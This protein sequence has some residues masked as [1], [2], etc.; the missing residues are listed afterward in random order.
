MKKI[1]YLTI[2]ISKNNKGVYNKIITKIEELKK[3]V[4]VVWVNISF[5]EKTITIDNS[6][7]NFKNFH[8]EFLQ[9][10]NQK[11]PIKG[12]TILFRHLY[13]NKTLS[14][15][16]SNNIVISE[17]N[18][19][20][21]EEYLTELLNLSFR[22][23]FYLIR[24]LKIFNNFHV[25]YYYKYLF[26][27]YAKNIKAFIGVTDEIM[28]Y[29]KKY[30][31][32]KKNC[33]VSNG[34]QTNRIQDSNQFLITENKE[35]N[36]LFFAGGDFYW[37]GFDRLI[38][39]FINSTSKE[40][41]FKIHYFGKK[42]KKNNIENVFYY[43]DIDTK[44]LSNLLLNNCIGIGTLKLYKKRLDEACPLKVRDYWSYGLPVILAYKDTDVI[45]N[46]HLQTYCLQFEN[47]NTP[48][49]FEKIVA[50]SHKLRKE[51]FQKKDVLEATKSVYFDTKM[52]KL[53]N[54]LNEL[55]D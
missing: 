36:L 33:I 8:I 45:N 47:N 46:I 23:W 2:N 26:Y 31:F 20:E 11:I 44:I 7:F 30:Y 51:G 22:D 34:I 14:D 10:I 18:S 53:F 48:I 37:N 29:E 13:Y 39:G 25:I 38:E 24:T 1:I 15:F 6:I 32:D 4:E 27:K 3:H 16:F 28:N 21:L 40:F 42:N 5:T 54:F 19:K 9:I 35:I 17:H 43:D 49:D 41:D 52:F 12:N 55:K 50:F